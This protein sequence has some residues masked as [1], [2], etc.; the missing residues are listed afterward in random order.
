M[1]TNQ[2]TG[3]VLGDEIDAP[4]LIGED[5]RQSQ[6]KANALKK[7]SKR[8]NLIFQPS[9]SIDFSE[10]I[11]TK[12]NKK[13]MILR[14]SLTTVAAVVRGSHYERATSVW[15]RSVGARVAL[16]GGA[17]D[18]G[19][20]L[21]GEWR[22]SADADRGA[23][24]CCVRLAV[25]CKRSGRSLGGAALRELLGALAGEPDAALPLLGLLVSASGFS[26][27][28]RAA[29]RERGRV[30][31]LALASVDAEHRSDAALRFCA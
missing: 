31:P 4:P 23:D 12:Q 8:N 14:R 1:R 15:L 13:N 7:Q 17:H 28:C 19:I 11:Y 20:D 3:G 18:G 25:Q 16:V 29:F 6:N 30:Q 26:P 24:E 2:M 5:W 10:K 21:R 27:A 9:L 22:L